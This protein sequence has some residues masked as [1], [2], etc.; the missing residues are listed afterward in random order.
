MASTPMTPVA[1]LSLILLL[2]T[3]I[4][5]TPKTTYLPVDHNKITLTGPKGV[6]TVHAVRSTYY[7]DG[8]DLVVSKTEENGIT[9]LTYRLDWQGKWASYEVSVKNGEDVLGD[10]RGGVDGGEELKD[11]GI[12]KEGVSVEDEDETTEPVGL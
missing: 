4:S 12:W 6:V 7:D 3:L 2:R 10:S 1:P 5:S 11:P 9:R 8:K